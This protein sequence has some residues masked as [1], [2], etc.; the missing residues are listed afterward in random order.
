MMNDPML[1]ELAG[2]YAADGGDPTKVYE[3][4]TDKIITESDKGYSRGVDDGY[5]EGYE[6]GFADGETSYE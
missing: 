3:W 1:Q 5:I 2:L 6:D 4:F